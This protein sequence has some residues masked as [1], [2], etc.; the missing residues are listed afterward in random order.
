M[1]WSALIRP[2]VTVLASIDIA[3]H[4]DKVMQEDD[5]RSAGLYL[6]YLFSPEGAAIA[7]QII[8]STW[9]HLNQLIASSTD[10]E[11][12]EILVQTV[13]HLGEREA[14]QVFRNCSPAL[15]PEVAD[16]LL[17]RIR[18]DGY[19]ED[20]DVLR[21][22]VRILGPNDVPVQ[23]ERVLRQLDAVH[24]GDVWVTTVRGRISAQQKHWSEAERSLLAA[25]ELDSAYSPALET[26]IVLLI[27]SGRVEEATLYLNQL[28]K[29]DSGE[30]NAIRKWLS[31]QD[32][33]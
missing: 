18:D 23:T 33:K 7:K 16:K 15:R 31:S 32:H 30:A 14:R 28:E 1:I 27:E 20:T 29:V 25:L 22:A 4:I 13:W 8:K 9:E 10:T 5:V 2:L 21:S 24:P 6:D 11:G 19:W 17:V 26:L 12:I 3:R